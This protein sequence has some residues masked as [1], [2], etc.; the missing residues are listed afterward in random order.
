[1]RVTPSWT[2]RSLERDRVEPGLVP[3][4]C[5]SGTNHRYPAAIAAEGC[6]RGAVKSAGTIGARLLIELGMEPY[7]AIRRVRA[8]RPGAIETAEQEQYVLA[9]TANQ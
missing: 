3:L 2:K 9:I 5:G 4:D 7:S 6:I 1:M 8:V